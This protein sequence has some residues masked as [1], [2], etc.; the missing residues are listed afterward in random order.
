VNGWLGCIF[1]AE[2]R[3][4]TISHRRRRQAS[5]PRLDAKAK[6]TGGGGEVW[7]I[8]GR[9]GDVGCRAIERERPPECPALPASVESALVA[10]TSEPPTALEAA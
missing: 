1:A 5:R 6:P 9:H 7:V 10:K 2:G 4:A 3:G 8:R